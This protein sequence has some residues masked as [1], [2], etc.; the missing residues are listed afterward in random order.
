[1]GLEGFGK[2]IAVG[3]PKYNHLLNKKGNFLAKDS[4]GSFITHTVSMISFFVA[5]T[6]S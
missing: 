6:D 5:L 2:V 3:S 4:Y 1:M